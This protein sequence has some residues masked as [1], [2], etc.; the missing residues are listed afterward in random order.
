[1]LIPKQSVCYHTAR[2]PGSYAVT[3]PELSPLQRA[4]DRSNQVI[5]PFWTGLAAMGMNLEGGERLV[6]QTLLDFQRDPNDYVHDARLSVTP[7][8]GTTIPIWR[9]PLV[10]Q[11]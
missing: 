6:L 8:E 9:A 1:M 3:V 4:W 2:R 10:S 5:T 7:F 11:A